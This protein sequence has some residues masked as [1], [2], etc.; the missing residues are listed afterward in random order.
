MFLGVSRKMAE[1]T[2]D[3]FSSFGFF[4]LCALLLLGFMSG[5]I[6]SW[7]TDLPDWGIIYASGSLPILLFAILTFLTSGG[8]GALGL[9]DYIHW[10]TIVDFFLMFLMSFVGG[11]VGVRAYQFLSAYLVTKRTENTE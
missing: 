1:F 8:H 9:T 10:R 7:L 5:S 6:L 3:W 11:F 2:Q 4:L